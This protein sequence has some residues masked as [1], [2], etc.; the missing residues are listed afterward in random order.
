MGRKNRRTYTAE[1]KAEAVRLVHEHGMTI[2]QV[3]RD[4][5]IHKTTIRNWVRSAEAGESG[6]SPA[7]PTSPTTLAEEIRRLRRENAILREER[8]I[9]KKATAFFAKETR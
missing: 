9:L 4:L 3:G 5:G 6:G 8:E 7:A 1:F 2:S